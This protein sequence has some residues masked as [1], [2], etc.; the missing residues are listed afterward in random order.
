MYYYTPVIKIYCTCVFLFCTRK[1]KI[2]SVHTPPQ[3]KSYS[4]TCIICI[5][6]SLFSVDTINSFFI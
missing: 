1:I 6:F 3:T 5:V 2:I 4:T